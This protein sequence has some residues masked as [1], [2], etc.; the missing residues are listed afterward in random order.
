MSPRSLQPQNR[1]TR[2][3]PEMATKR[4]GLRL[5]H[6]AILPEPKRGNIPTLVMGWAVRNAWPAFGTMSDRGWGSGTCVPPLPGWAG[7]TQVEVAKNAAQ[8]RPNPKRAAGWGLPS[9]RTVCSSTN[10]RT[11][12]CTEG[13]FKTRGGRG[14][15][16]HPRG[17]YPPPPWGGG[18]GAPP[19]RPPP[20]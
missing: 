4:L 15:S 1:M 2:C 5:Q 14:V 16:T 19:P 18:S 13:F 7:N 3:N 8:P 17:H 6:P 10:S 12:S 11:L 20:T 9:V